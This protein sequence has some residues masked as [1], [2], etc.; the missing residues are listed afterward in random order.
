[1]SCGQY[2]QFAVVAPGTAAVASIGSMAL[3]K[4][5]CRSYNGQAGRRQLWHLGVPHRISLAKLS[6]ATQAK[7]AADSLLVKPGRELSAA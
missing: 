4:D 5:D 6:I 3:T 1:M 2:A 7:E